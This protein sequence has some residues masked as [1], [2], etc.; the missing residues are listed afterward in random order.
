ME[1]HLGLLLAVVDRIQTAEGSSTSTLG[2]AQ[3]AQQLQEELQRLQAAVVSAEAGAGRS[4]F[5]FS[6]VFCC[7][8]RLGLTIGGGHGLLYSR[9]TSS[10]FSCSKSSVPDG[11]L[12]I[13]RV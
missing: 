13:R 8:H 3:Q 11:V 1:Q 4:V 5:L 6:P 7:F 2:W 10:S 9:R 12:L